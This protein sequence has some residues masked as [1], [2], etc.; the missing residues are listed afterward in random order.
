MEKKKFKLAAPSMT[1]TLLLACILAAILTFVLPAGQYERILDPATGRNVAIADSYQQID[2]DPVG[3]WKL[4]QAPFDGVIAAAELIGVVLIAGG[5]LGIIVQTGA[6]HAAINLLVKKL[7]KKD[8]LLLAAMT[9]AVAAATSFLGVGEELICFIP[10]LLQVIVSLGYDPILVVA[11]FS[12]GNLAGLAFALTS[13][14]NTV[15][16]Q[17]IAELP[18]LSGMG[19]RTIGSVGA[20]GLVLIYIFFHARKMKENEYH[21]LAVKTLGGQ[22]VNLEEYEMTKERKLV[23]AVTFAYLCILIYGV[24]VLKWWLGP[25]SA[26]FVAM[27]FTGGMLYYKSFNKVSDAFL[28][29][30]TKM[31]VPA[32]LLAFSRSIMVIM[33]TGMIADTVVY[34]MAGPLS[35]VSGVFAAWGI[36]IANF[37]INVLIPSCSG[38]AAVVMPILTPLADLVGITRQ[39][40]VQAFM[41]ADAFGD[42]ILPTYPPLL[43]ALTICGVSY[44]RWFKFVWKIALIMTIWS[45]LILAI[46]VKINWG[47]F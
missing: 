13:P 34:L 21:K 10:L 16:A 45:F 11:V 40:A 43:A 17:T 42:C 47:P 27:G 25:M 46:A 30:A 5:G 15:I 19:L 36:Y 24:I 23:L 44:G 8:H 41:S 39:T 32:I 26:V 6:I 37:I 28:E 31:A 35:K 20:I 33:E 12:L 1:A 2:V 9:I 4:L 22:T 14:Y 29:E 7:G 18:L 3:L 38:Q